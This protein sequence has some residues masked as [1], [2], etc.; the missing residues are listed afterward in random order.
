N[1]ALAQL[2][3]NIVLCLGN[4]GL[5]WNAAPLSR[6]KAL[7]GRCHPLVLRALKTLPTVS[8]WA[9]VFELRRPIR[10]KSLMESG[11]NTDEGRG[12]IETTP[13]WA[14][15][16]RGRRAYLLGNCQPFGP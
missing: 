8:F 14:T 16:K 13:P 2:C 3:E 7:V 1:R 10:R 6:A 9:G 11:V 12:R 15:P 5:G 4:W